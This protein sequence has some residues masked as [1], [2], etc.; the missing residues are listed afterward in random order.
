[1]SRG[2]GFAERRSARSLIRRITASLILGGTNTKKA[3]WAE[4][5][6]LLPFGMLGACVGAYALLTLP[7]TPILLT[8]GAFTMFFGFRNIFGLQPVGLLS[9]GWAIPAGLAGGANR[10]GGG[11]IASRKAR[12]SRRIVAIAY[13]ASEVASL[14]GNRG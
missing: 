2:D 3:N 6:V 7:T 11:K 4:I 14:A 9:R 12:S 1:M 10:R 5:K 8:L 13:G